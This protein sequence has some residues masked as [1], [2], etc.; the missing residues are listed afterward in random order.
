VFRYF[1]VAQGDEAVCIE[2]KPQ[3]RKCTKSQ[4]PS[5]SKLQKRL[6]SLECLK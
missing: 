5:M 6:C 2:S 1:T 3:I 4:M